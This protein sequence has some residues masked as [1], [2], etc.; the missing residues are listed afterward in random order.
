MKTKVKAYLIMQNQHKNA[1][2]IDWTFK[3]R[4]ETVHEIIDSKPILCLEWSYHSLVIARWSRY[5]GYKSSCVQLENDASN[6]VSD[7]EI[8]E[9]LGLE[10]EVEIPFVYKNKTR[11]GGAFSKNLNVT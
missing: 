6:S 2:T 7:A 4:C 10:T 5:V 9:M 1:S 3:W 11:Q 8:E